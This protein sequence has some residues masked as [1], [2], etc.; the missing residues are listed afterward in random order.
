MAGNFLF[1]D[2]VKHLFDTHAQR[3]GEKWNHLIIYASDIRLVNS[4][5][6][7]KDKPLQWALDNFY[8]RKATSP[9]QRKSHN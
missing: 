8:E 5:K 9:K 4:L 6:V 1:T 7:V 3:Y 2:H